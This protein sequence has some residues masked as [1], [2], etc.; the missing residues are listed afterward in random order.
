MQRKIKVR[1]QITYNE[2]AQKVI[3]AGYGVINLS[4][5]AVK[6]QIDFL[7]ECRLVKIS[8][9]VKGMNVGKDGK[10]RPKNQRIDYDIVRRFKQLIEEFEPVDEVEDE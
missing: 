8:E 5:E 10:K 3:G 1:K 7:I 2:F 9:I 4:D 6:A